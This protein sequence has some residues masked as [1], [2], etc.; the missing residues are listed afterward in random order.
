MFLM[1]SQTLLK[2][3][4]KIKFLRLKNLQ[5]SL[6]NVFNCFFQT[7]SKIKNKTKLYKT[8]NTGTYRGV[9]RNFI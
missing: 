1:F 2:I 4:N 6:T 7:Q 8:L 5:N 3:R 9:V